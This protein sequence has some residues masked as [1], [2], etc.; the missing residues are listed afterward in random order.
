MA[1]GV[2]GVAHLTRPDGFVAITPDWVP[3]PQLV[4][5]LTGMAE[6]A[7]AIGL[8]IPPLRKAAGIG[9]ALYALCVWPAN[10]HHALSDIGLNGVHLS[11]WYHGPRLALQP[12]IIWWALW[13]S[14]V[15]DWP[16]G[17]KD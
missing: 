7:G 14:G 6:I 4:V 5:A 8:M 13:A 10:F 16:F 1:Y 15:T 12:I 2:A 17:R 3:A 11:W 9:L